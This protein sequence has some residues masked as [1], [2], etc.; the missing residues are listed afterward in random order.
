MGNRNLKRA[1]VVSMTV[2]KLEASIERL[3]FKK[4]KLRCA[5]SYD[6]ERCKTL[7][8]GS[9]ALECEST[10][11]VV[12]HLFSGDIFGPPA[13]VPTLKLVVL[14]AERGLS[15]GNTSFWLCK[16]HAPL[17]IE[18][19]LIHVK[20]GLVDVSQKEEPNE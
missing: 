11:P 4:Q 7:G 14:G 15:V 17:A 9:V 12:S 5:W 18:A 16:D 20:R 10:P 6:G 2:P 8:T 3:V 1:K 19:G 13:S